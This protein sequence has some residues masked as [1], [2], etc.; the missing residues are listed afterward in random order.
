[1]AR[2]AKPPPGYVSNACMLR[3]GALAFTWCIGHGIMP[4]KY[5]V[6]HRAQ[7]VSQIENR[8][9][10]EGLAFYLLDI[11]TGNLISSLRALKT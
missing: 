9:F 7:A 2:V 6:L 8:T 1:M 5:L 3:K 10:T 11:L 4:A